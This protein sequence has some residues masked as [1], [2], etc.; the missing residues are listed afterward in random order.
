MF[1]P[2]FFEPSILEDDYPNQC[3]WNQIKGIHRSNE[4]GQTSL[5]IHLVTLPQ[6]GH[7]PHSTL[8]PSHEL[9]AKIFDTNDLV[10]EISP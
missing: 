10:F 1:E 4:F 7:I 2:L 9:V 8:L 5:E 3:Q 6:P